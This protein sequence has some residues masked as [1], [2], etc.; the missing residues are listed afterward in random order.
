MPPAGFEPE[1]PASER[2][3]NHTLDGQNQDNKQRRNYTLQ[4]MDESEIK[5]KE[6]Q[7]E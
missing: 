6:G 1:F 4:L 2:P 7:K 3:Q 5:S